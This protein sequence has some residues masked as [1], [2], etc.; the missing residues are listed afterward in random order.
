MAA[1]MQFARRD[2]DICFGAAKGPEPLMNEQNPQASHLAVRRR[3]RAYPSA[4][5][6]LHNYKW[7]Q[8]PAEIRQAF[9]DAINGLTGNS[10]D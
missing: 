7:S 3:I 1:A 9:N 8:I 4:L 6:V 10:V 5:R 2:S